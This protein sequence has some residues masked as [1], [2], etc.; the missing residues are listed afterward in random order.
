MQSLTLGRGLQ[1]AK[2]LPGGLRPGSLAATYLLEDE[3]AGNLD[4]EVDLK[5]AVGQGGGFP[6]PGS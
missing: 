4:S 3:E 1:A 2:C 5:K 6:G